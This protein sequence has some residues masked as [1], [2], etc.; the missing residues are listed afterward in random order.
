MCY[1]YH[2]NKSISQLEKRFE[3]EV[4][5]KQGNMFY[6]YIVNGFNKPNMPIIALDKPDKIE[7]AR[8]GLIP[9]WV[10]DLKTFKANTLNARMEELKEK[11]SYRSS[12]SN[13]CVVP[14]DAFQEWHWLDPKGK[15]KE[16]YLMY[17]DDLEIFS[18][19]G[20]FSDWKDPETGEITRSYTL[21]TTVGTGLMKDIHNADPEDPRM[22]MVLNPDSEKEYLSSGKLEIIN[23]RLKA[24]RI[25]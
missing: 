6:D 17:F 15:Q 23:D 3:A 13:R 14:A 19:P 12:I 8:W 10:K 22:V 16:K 7:F 4:I 1:S 5:H 20:I 18:F 21:L 11:P 2:I 25:A 9:G 24:R